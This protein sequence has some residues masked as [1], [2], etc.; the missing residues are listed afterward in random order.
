MEQLAVREKA[1]EK[2]T[3]RNRRRNNRTDHFGNGGDATDTT[4]SLEDEDHEQTHLRGGVLRASE[5]K[6][7]ANGVKDVDEFRKLGD[8][9]LSPPKTASP[10][11]VAPKTE[12]N[13]TVTYA[14]EETNN[15][16]RITDK[17]ENLRRRRAMLDDHDKFLSL[18]R[19]RGKSV[20]EELKAKENVKD[21]CGYDSRLSWSDE[22]FESW[23]SSPE[24]QKALTTA[25]L[26][27]PHRE[28]T[29][30]EDEEIGRGVCLKKRCERHKAW[31]KLQQQEMAFERETVRQEMKRLDV[32]EKGIRNRAMIRHL[33]A[34]DG[35]EPMDATAAG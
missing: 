28:T 21:I 3:A 4:Q 23:R 26:G 30:G 34:A 18:V 25:V 33:E 13:E 24:G 20:L 15:L 17:K 27:P 7:L 5:L 10:N 16:T 2:P 31:Y 29:G 11:G 12:H 32:E 8:G 1:A 6:A 35:G 9:I 22:E 14:E 19:N